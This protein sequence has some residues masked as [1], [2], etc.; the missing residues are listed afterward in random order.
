[1]VR[2]LIRSCSTRLSVVGSARH[3]VLSVLTWGTVGTHM[4]Y[5]GE[6]TLRS[7]APAGAEASALLNREMRS[8]ISFDKGGH[9]EPIKARPPATATALARHWHRHRPAL[10]RHWP[11][12]GTGTTTGTGPALARHGTEPAWYAIA[13][14]CGCAAAS[15]ACKVSRACCRSQRC[16]VACRHTALAPRVGLRVDFRAVLSGFSPDSAAMASASSRAACLP[17]GGWRH[18]V[19]SAVATSSATRCNAIMLQP[20]PQPATVL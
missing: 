3:G 10:A 16:H 13:T 11:D 6:P 1:M 9:W 2:I 19:Y 20:L 4:G 5:Y 17:A 18:V 12:T 15:L 8:L 7:Q 14:C